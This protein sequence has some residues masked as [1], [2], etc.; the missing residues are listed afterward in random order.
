MEWALQVAGTRAFLSNINVDCIGQLTLRDCTP[1]NLKQLVIVATRSV[2][3]YR[4]ISFSLLSQAAAWKGMWGKA[5]G[6]PELCVMDKTVSFLPCSYGC[7]FPSHC[8]LDQTMR[9]APL[10]G[11]CSRKSWFT[12]FPIPNLATTAMSCHT[13]AAGGG[14][15]AGPRCP[16]GR[17][18]LPCGLASWVPTRLRCPSHV[19]PGVVSAT[20]WAGQCACTPGLGT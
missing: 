15:G 1:S 4:L 16:A 10:L 8:S 3:C 20:G 11:I 19:A 17:P 2:V 14:T 9:Q 18:A 12:T 13:G 6:P 5:A 7:P